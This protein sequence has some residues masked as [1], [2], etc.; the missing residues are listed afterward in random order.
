MCRGAA[1]VLLGMNANSTLVNRA[2]QT[3]LD[4]APKQSGVR[5]LLHDDARWR[6]MLEETPLPCRVVLVRQQRSH[7]HLP[8]SWVQYPMYSE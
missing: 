3:P 4:L 8:M 6:C 5:E 2:R 1:E 7:F